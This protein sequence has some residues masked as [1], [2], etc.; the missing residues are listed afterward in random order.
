MVV[1][2]L[3]L[4][5]IRTYSDEP[6][7]AD[8]LRELLQIARSS[9]SWANSQPWSFLVIRDRD[10]LRRI[11]ELRPPMAW[12]ADV[13]LAIAIVLDGAG[14]SQAYDEGRVTERLLI[15]ADMLGLGAG[16]AWFG[17]D[18]QAAAAKR[19]LVIPADRTARPLVA[20]RR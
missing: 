2:Q 4:R 7:S 8:A 17:D 12:L 14:L 18:T 1:E 16:A 10:A 11:S 9:G 3:R 13:P 15:A 19:I 6:V 5:Q 20:I